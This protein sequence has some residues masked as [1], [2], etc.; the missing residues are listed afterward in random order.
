MSYS[1]E[2]QE[3]VLVFDNSTGSWSVYSTFPK[4]IRKL[5]GIGEMEI[6]ESEDDRPIAVQGKLSEKQVSIKKVREMSDEQR[7]AVSKRMKE[8]HNK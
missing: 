1:K 8:L 5:M 4:H 2:E 7:E 6:R 3:T